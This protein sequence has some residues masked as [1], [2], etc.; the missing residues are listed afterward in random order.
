[1]PQKTS[2]FIRPDDRNSLDLIKELI[3]FFESYSIITMLPDH[4]IIQHDARLANNIA[5]PDDYA[6]NPDFIIVI[7]GDGTF[8]R[9]SRYFYKLEKPIFGINRG[10]LG[11]LTEFNPHEAPHYLSQFLNGELTVS[12]RIMLEAIHIRYGQEISRNVFLNDAVISKGAFSRPIQLSIEIDGNFLNKYYGDGIIIATPTGSTAY[13]L[14][15]GG[16]IILPTIPHVY[17]VNPVC[18]HM[19]GIRPMIIPISSIVSA[20]VISKFEFL[21]LTIDGQEALRIEG[22]DKIIIQKAK[23]ALKI[24]DHP[25]RCY[26]SILR[27]KLGWGIQKG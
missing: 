6:N 1:M 14:S 19:L 26:Y 22:E 10:R 9:A 27:E 7:G 20:Q 16:P 21:L 8:L 3:N 4:D 24:V 18:P 17:I 5:H 11:F 15:A 12:E 23:H 2:I 13:S 25:D